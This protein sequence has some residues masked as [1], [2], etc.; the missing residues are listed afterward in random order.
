MN[1]VAIYE[2]D[3]YAWTVQ[4]AALIRQGNWA[5]I[6]RE[7]LAEE[8]ESMGRSE[9]RE[10]ISRLAV[11][12]MHLLKWQFQPSKRSTSW[13]GTI[14]EQRKQLKLLLADN[15]SLKYAADDRVIDAYD[16]AIYAAMRETRLKKSTFPSQ[17]PYTFSQVLAEN[18][19]PE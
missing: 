2:E 6:D 13:E 1:Q 11:L 8:I 7:N 4:T 5:A 12:I 14:I 10:L 19:W 3:F 15:P 17:C 18:Y 16:I 9:K